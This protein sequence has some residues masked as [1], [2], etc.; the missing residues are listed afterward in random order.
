[1]AFI[2]TPEYAVLQQELGSTLDKIKHWVELNNIEEADTLAT[3]KQKLTLP[4][5]RITLLYA[6]GKKC[7][8]KIAVLLD[9]PQIDLSIRKTV[10][11]NLLADKELEKCINGCYSRIVNAAFHLQENIAGRQQIRYW[12]RS[13]L[14]DIARSVATQRPFA[15]PYSY[16]ELL[17]KTSDCSEQYNGLHANNYLLLKAKEHGFPI[18]NV[19]DEGA[20]E[21]GKGIPSEDKAIIVNHYIIHLEKVLTAKNLVSFLSDK[22]HENF[23][24]IMSDDLDY[25]EKMDRILN[26]LNLLGEDPWFTSKKVGLDEII[27]TEGQLKSSDYLKITITER[28]IKQGWFHKENMDTLTVAHGL[29]PYRKFS[30]AIELTWFWIDEERKTFLQLTKEERFN[31]LN[32]LQKQSHENSMAI[33]PFPFNFFIKTVEDLI[34]V[35]K[36]SPKKEQ[37]SFLAWVS[38]EYAVSLIKKR[39]SPKLFLELLNN[40]KFKSEKEL[41]L[42]KNG[43]DFIRTMVTKGIFKNDFRTQ[44]MGI[45]LQDEPG[46]YDFNAK[47]EGLSITKVLIKQLIE[48][49]FKNFNGC[50]FYELNQLNYLDGI[51]FSKLNL[52][53][54]SFF[55]SMAYVRFDEAELA[56]A[57]FWRGLSYVSFKKT[58]LRQVEFRSLL[59][60]EYVTLSLEGAKLSTVSFNALIRT[61][62]YDFTGVNLQA[63]DFQHADIKDRLQN[64]DFSNANLESVNLN[65]LNLRNVIFESANLA[66]TNLIGSALYPI[67]VNEKTNLQ[68]SQLTLAMLA[69]LNEKGIKIFDGCNIITNMEMYEEEDFLIFHKT[70]FKKAYFTGIMFRADFIESDLTEAVFSPSSTFFLTNTDEN[71]NEVLM[72][73][74]I[75]AKKSY[76]N[77]ITFNRVRFIEGVK[78]EESSLKGTLFNKVEMAA[79]LLFVFYEHGTRNFKGVSD[80]KGQILKKLLPFPVLDAELNKRTFLYL[81]RQGLRDFRGSNLNSFYLGQV[82]VEQAISEIDLKLEGALYKTS[83]LECGLRHKRA[84]ASANIVSNC[85]AYFLFQ[86][87][88]ISERVISREDIEFI[89]KS[90]GVQRSFFLKEHVLGAK[91]LFT[92][93]QHISE[94]NFYWGYRPDESDL[95][96]SL[97]FTRETISSDGR[98]RVSLSYYFY[99]KY[100][101]NTVFTLF[102]RS[103]LDTGFKNIVVKY[104]DQASQASFIQFKNGILSLGIEQRVLSQKFLGIL[105]NLKNTP[106]NPARPK[107]EDYS[108]RLRH[109]GLNVRRKTGQG[110]RAGMRQGAQYEIGMGLMHII[111][112]WLINRDPE[113]KEVDAQTKESFKVLA[114]NVTL[115]VGKE[116]GANERQIEIAFNVAKQCIDRGECSSEELVIKDVVDSMHRMRPDVVIG[117]VYAWKKIKDFF[118]NIG[119]Y[120]TEKF[121]DVKQFFT[122]T[123]NQTRLLPNTPVWGAPFAVYRSRSR[124]KRKIVAW[125]ESPLL[126]GLIKEIEAGFKVL[127]YDV[128]LNDVFSEEDL[129]GFLYEIWWALASHG[130][131]STSSHE[132][133]L[134]LL[135]NSTFTEQELNISLENSFFIEPPVIELPLTTSR[136][137]ATSSRR[138]KRSAALKI[139]QDKYEVDE[140]E[141]RAQD[142]IAKNETV[143]RHKHK[144]KNK[145]RITSCFLPEASD[146]ANRCSHESTQRLVDQ[147]PL[148]KEGMKQANR[149]K[150]KMS[151]FSGGSQID[152]NQSFY[153]KLGNSLHVNQEKFHKQA[154]AYKQR[155]AL[156]NRT[157]NIKMNQHFAMPSKPVSCSVFF[158]TVKNKSLNNYLGWNTPKAITNSTQKNDHHFYQSIRTG[159]SNVTA[160]SDMQSTLFALNVLV[161]SKLQNPYQPPL[162][163]KKGHLHERA[164]R[165]LERMRRT[166]F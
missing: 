86:N 75:N 45:S 110:Y 34:F 30:S 50:K 158:K 58:D 116:R 18:D 157:P 79:D 124:Q 125:Y 68:G 76:L 70:S 8:E 139:E 99:Q 15:M 156:S 118:T 150:E 16:Q 25:S 128:Q 53:Q 107:K 28:L 115:E 96:K 82:L 112:Q 73:V 33:R 134:G 101:L 89:A 136:V 5:D 95:I 123:R 117:N 133:I 84:V 10:I 102:A 145:S 6:D 165:R 22:L 93:E 108:T 39:D 1:M 85:A 149:K 97:D 80:L 132:S 103:L 59:G 105:N 162:M 21:F 151:V 26:K 7:L 166:G 109:I 142:Y 94:V 140:I 130:I 114:R 41:F 57:K 146:Q 137:T 66:N 36:N 46:N 49:G 100:T 120:L 78:F 83:I 74:S 138:Q 12:I 9:D 135:E 111:S 40:L 121:D 14:S 13:H 77:N 31:K 52:K 127:D 159:I 141:K 81:Y 48:N 161:R 56:G 72:Q 37:E 122:Q 143:E 67:H 60:S 92:L 27:S 65:K 87:K 163:Q 155:G 2:N 69:D 35:V 62:I 63:V 98:N 113:P 153:I 3:F 20:I 147:Q 88:Q 106:V 51:D 32:Y 154:N 17:C 38:M 144:R 42:K 126:M 64:L 61:H 129:A 11:T 91:S 119:N 71:T 29:L 19:V 164:E 43:D 90:S 104:Y 148:T 24:S 4:S 54:T 23:Q 55:Q 152:H 44:F 131:N 47:Q 160:S